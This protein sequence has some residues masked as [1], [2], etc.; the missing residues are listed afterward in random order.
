MS[1]EKKR[2]IFPNLKNRTLKFKKIPAENLGIYTYFEVFFKKIEKNLIF[3][4][5]NATFRAFKMYYKREGEM[6]LKKETPCADVSKKEII[7][8]YFDMIYRLALSRTG[9]K[10]HADDVTQEVFLRYIEQTKAFESEE[11]I[12][13]WLIRVAINCSKDIFTS[14]WFKKTEPLNEDIPFDTPEKGDVYY[15]MQELPQKY[16]TVIHL[17]YYEDFSVNEIAKYLKLNESTVRSQ[18]HRGRELLKIKLKEGYD[19]V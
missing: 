11:H 19:F 10:S 4:K 1:D 18:L 5:I 15:A 17:F 8:K 16:R 6:S 13:A 14:S 12:K 9:D 3:L 2:P 7:D